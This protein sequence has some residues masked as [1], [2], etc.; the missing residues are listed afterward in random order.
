MRCAAVRHTWSPPPPLPPLPLPLT[1]PCHPHSFCLVFDVR[2][3]RADGRAFYAR[4]RFY[5]TFPFNCIGN[6]GTT[7]KARSVARPATCCTAVLHC[8]R[9][10]RPRTV[11]THP[12]PA[13]FPSHSIDRAKARHFVAFWLRGGRAVAKGSPDSP[14]MGGLALGG[15]L[16]P[17]ALHRDHQTRFVST[18][19]M[20]VVAYVYVVVHV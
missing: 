20:R 7:S 19:C 16:G 14:R 4:P 3:A 9:S 6:A 5:N 17:P 1:P 8:L 15:V 2:A 11:R 10:H 12:P 13:P 18:L